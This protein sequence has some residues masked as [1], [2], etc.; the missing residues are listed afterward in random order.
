MAS[1][2]IKPDEIAKLSAQG[3]MISP[4]SEHIVGFDGI[5]ITLRPNLR[6]QAQVYE[7]Q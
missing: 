6:P 4:A 7:T 1:R 5:V 3:D 2:K